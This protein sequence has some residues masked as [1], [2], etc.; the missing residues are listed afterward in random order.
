MKAVIL[1]A[2]RGS[3][4]L[5]LTE[6][7]PKCLLPVANTS[8]LG[9]QLDTLEAEGI[10][11]VTIVTGFNS[12]LV[13]AEI[14]TRPGKMSVD[15]IYN[16]FFQVADNLASCWMARASMDED[17]LLI[18]GDTLFERAL[19]RTVLDSP[20]QPIQVT[21][22]KKSTYDS[23]DMKVTLDGS[24]LLAI[25]KTLTKTETHGESI[26]L[27]RF[28]NTGR[29]QFTTMLE[30]ILH[31]PDG[32]S[33]WFLKALDRLA[34]EGTHVETLDINGYAWQE[35]DTPEDYQDAWALFDQQA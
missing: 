7:R 2:G 5:P 10:E 34:Q 26:G 12:H 23:D 28:M 11:S 31:T 33:V 15:C 1:S 27:L 14:A 35:I 19:L 13:E 32:T 16:P 18:N 25:G 4:L 6:D 20:E 29:G 8:V 17:F 24:R 9:F 22:D 21:I 3:R 30:T